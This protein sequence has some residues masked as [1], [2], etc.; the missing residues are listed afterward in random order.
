ML[1]FNKRNREWNGIYYVFVDRKFY[2]SSNK[3]LFY[4]FCVNIKI[5]SNLP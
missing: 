1:E 4:I 2:F 5:E 3:K